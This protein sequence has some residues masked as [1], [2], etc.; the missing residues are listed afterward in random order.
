M[1]DLPK[2]KSLGRYLTPAYQREDEQRRYML[3]QAH[4]NDMM[5]E[6]MEWIAGG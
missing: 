4:I 5:R 1:S 2:R 3:R 6:A